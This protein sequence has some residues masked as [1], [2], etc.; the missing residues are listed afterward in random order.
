MCVT[1]GFIPAAHKLETGRISRRGL[2]TG[3]AGTSPAMTLLDTIAPSLGQLEYRVDPRLHG[4]L[5]A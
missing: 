2:R 3:V 1:A 4:E 5:A